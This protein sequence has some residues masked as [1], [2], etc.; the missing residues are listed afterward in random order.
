MNLFRS[1]LLASAAACACQP[2]P[3][4]ND[5]T[6][7]SCDEATLLVEQERA[8]IDERYSAGCVADDDCVRTAP[9]IDCGDRG[10]ISACSDSVL[11]SNLRSHEEDLVTFA[12]DLCPRLRERCSAILECT[13][14]DYVN[15]GAFCRNEKCVGFPD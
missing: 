4:A 3:A 6:G 12:A 14:L 2:P 8:T 5:E 10:D 1:F 13:R 11:A 15:I 7:L 9:R